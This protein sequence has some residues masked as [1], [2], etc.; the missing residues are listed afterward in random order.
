MD[1]NEARSIL[2]EYVQRYRGRTYQDLLQ[3]M[4][5]V[6]VYEVHT[7]SGK[8]YQLEFQAIYDDKKMKHIRVHG[9]ISD[10]GIRAFFPLSEDFIISPDGTFIGE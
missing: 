2:K 9:S 5:N 1:K 7:E 6:D 10:R 8:F 4:T 3:L